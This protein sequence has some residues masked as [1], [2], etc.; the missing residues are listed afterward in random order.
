MGLFLDQTNP[1]PQYTYVATFKGQTIDPPSDIDNTHFR[2]ALH[3]GD[4]DKL[5]VA[6]SDCLASYANQASSDLFDTERSTDTD[7]KGE[8][9][10]EGF[11]YYYAIND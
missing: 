7:E 8:R 2:S 1:L 6:D 9:N 11:Y 10:T 5:F 3:F 4:S